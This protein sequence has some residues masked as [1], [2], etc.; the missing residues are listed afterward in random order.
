MSSMDLV[1]FRIVAVVTLKGSWEVLSANFCLSNK[2]QRWSLSQSKGFCFSQIYHFQ[3]AFSFPHFCTP[4]LVLIPLYLIPL[5]LDYKL[6]RQASIY[7][8]CL[9]GKNE[10]CQCIY[11]R[12]YIK[13]YLY[14]S[15]VAFSITNLI[16]RLTM[17]FVNSC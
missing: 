10:T 13:V 1:L 12:I 17:D 9:T 15:G 8:F 3:G 16:A 4:S 7:L 11:I 6:I 14:T 2:N 5:V